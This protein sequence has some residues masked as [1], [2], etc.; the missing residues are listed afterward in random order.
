MLDYVQD[1]VV[2]IGAGFFGVAITGA[3]KNH[4]IS[5]SSSDVS[6]EGASIYFLK[7]M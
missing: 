1:S 2:S 5:S 3:N 6:E 7:H 4:Q